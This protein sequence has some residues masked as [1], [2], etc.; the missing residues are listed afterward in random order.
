MAGSPRPILPY[1]R[2]GP[3][4]HLHIRRISPGGNSV[5]FSLS[6]LVRTPYLC[7]R[8][9]RLEYIL[10]SDVFFTGI[11]LVDSL[12]IAFHYNSSA[13]YIL[14]LYLEP[15]MYLPSDDF[16]RYSISLLQT[17]AAG[18]PHTPAFLSHSFFSRYLA[19]PWT[20]IRLQDLDSLMDLDLDLH[21]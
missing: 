20:W 21:F 10:I 13:S 8:Y 1:P 16:S 5:P 6:R 18:R 4:S 15:W 19:L 9:E 3:S 12:F 11:L 17:Y 2:A 7:S 14:L